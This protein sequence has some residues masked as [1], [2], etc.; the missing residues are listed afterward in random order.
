MTKLYILLSK[1]QLYGKY[2]ILYT[3]KIKDDFLIIFHQ[4][5]KLC[6]IESC[7]KTLKYIKQV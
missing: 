6:V 2:T 3:N 1:K 7:P 4:T 5:D